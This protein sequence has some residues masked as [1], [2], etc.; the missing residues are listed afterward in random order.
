LCGFLRTT[1][2]SLSSK[3]KLNVSKDNEQTK[4]C[5]TFEKYMSEFNPIIYLIAAIGGEVV[6]DVAK[7]HGKKAY[8]LF[9]N[10]RHP[11]IE[12]GIA[13]YNNPEEMQLKLDAKPDIKASIEQN[14][15]DN[16]V[17]FDEIIR[18]LRENPKLVVNKFHSEGNEKVI[19]I[20]TNHGTIN[21]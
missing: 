8:E 18:V 7:H 5:S 11:I 1:R 12:L 14:V 6:K 15:R 13:D 2:F 3:I 9:N 21:M 17:D 16:Q 4:V 10:L 19:N 20:E